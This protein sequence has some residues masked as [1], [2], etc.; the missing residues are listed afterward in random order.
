MIHDLQ[1]L[2]PLG[3]RSERQLPPDAQDSD[4]IV[5]RRMS[6]RIDDR[7]HGGRGTR[8]A[9]PVTVRQHVAI[10]LTGLAVAF[11][12]AM[13]SKMCSSIGLFFKMTTPINS[14]RVWFES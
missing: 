8:G 10:R 6:A 2:C 9:A 5:R 12:A 4:R 11:P 14:L 13:C 7:R 1:G 3:Q